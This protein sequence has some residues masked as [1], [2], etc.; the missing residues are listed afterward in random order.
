MT[1][2]LALDINN[3]I[4]RVHSP[5]YWAFPSILAVFALLDLFLPAK[6]V[7]LNTFDRYFT[8]FKFALIIFFTLV[9]TSQGLTG[10][11]I[12][13]LPQN[14]LAENYLNMD[15]WNTPYG[16]VYREYVPQRFEWAL[17]LVYFLGGM[18][19]VLATWKY[20]IKFVKNTRLSPTNKIVN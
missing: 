14:W 13:H 11:C 8:H 2:E 10:G 19:S 20:Y 17:R 16:L 7:Y 4:D 9:A 5:Y 3:F 1:Y 6:L 12:L 15:Y 18:I